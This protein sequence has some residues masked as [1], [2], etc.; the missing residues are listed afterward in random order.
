MSYKEQILKAIEDEFKIIDHLYS[1]I[2]EGKFDFKPADETR[3]IIQLLRYITWCSVG[4]LKTFID[5]DDD[6]PNYEFYREFSEKAK[7][8]KTSDFPDAMKQQLTDIKKLFEKFSEKDLLDK[9]V[10]MPDQEKYPL[11]EAIINTSVKHLTAYRMQLFIYLKI[12]GLKL[13]TVNCWLGLD[14]EE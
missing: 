9:M 14:P 6:S 12:L 2:P 3:T 13:N 11:G 7:E 10:M 5:G 1:K 8:M 4:T